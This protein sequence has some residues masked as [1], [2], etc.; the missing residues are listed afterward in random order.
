MQALYKKLISSLLLR[1]SA[2]LYTLKI[3]CVNIVIKSK[4]ICSKEL[5]PKID[6]T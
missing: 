5:V 1:S 3:R 2:D 6:R 4:Y